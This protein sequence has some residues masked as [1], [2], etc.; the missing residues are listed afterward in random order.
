MEIKQVTLD[1]IEEKVSQKVATEGLNNTLLEVKADIAAGF[2]VAQLTRKRVKQFL[3]SETIK[4]PATWWQHFKETYFPSLL[5]KRF[6]VKYEHIVV[7]AET[8]YDRI[9]IPNET[10][11]FRVYVADGKVLN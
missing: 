8:F 4:R 10:T 7:S 6:P 5:L 1:I 2:L 3:G 11:E 9:A